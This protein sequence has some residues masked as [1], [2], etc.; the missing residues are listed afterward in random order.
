MSTT[1]TRPQIE[2][3]A[4][5][6]Q[7]RPAVVGTNVERR[8]A[9]AKVRGEAKYAADIERPDLIHGKAVRSPHPRARI[10]AIDAAAA[11]ALPGV[12]AVL[13]AADIPGHKLVGA[14]AVKDQAVLAESMT[15]FVGE[16]VALV[17]AGSAETAAQGARLVKVDYEVLDPVTD[18]EEALAPRAP[19]LRPGGNLCHQLR[20][21]RG[22]FDVVAAAAD[23]VVTNTYTTQA[24]DHGY[25]EPDAVVAEP[26]GDGVTLYVSSK[27]PHNDQGEIAGVLAMPKDKVHI[28]VVAVGGSF[29]GKPDIPMLCMAGLM[30]ARYNRPAK[31]VL[32]REECLA[33]KTKRHAYKMVYS[34]AVRANG[35]ILGLRVR[36]VADA[37]AYAG[38]TPTV[39]S[40]GLIH[41]AGP[42]RAPVVDMEIKAAYTNNPSGGAMRGYGVPQT[43]FAAERQMDVIARRLGISPFE[44]RMRNIL[45]AG[46]VTATGQDVADGSMRALMELTAQRAAAL[47]GSGGRGPHIRRAWG[48]GTFFYGAGRTGVA[49]SARVSIGLQPDGLVHV[50]VGT[51]DTGQ[52]SDTAL[53]QIAAEELG[54]PFEMVQLT[55]ADTDL[56]YDCG[57]STA[58]RVTYVVG[59]A[60]RR[61]ATELKA[62]LLS[63]LARMAG[64][65]AAG[66]I[67]DRD[68]LARLSAY[69]LA[70]GLAGEAD[71]YFETTTTKMD[72]NGQGSPYGAYTYGVQMSRVAVNTLTGKVDV[73]RTVCAYDA[74][75]VVNP[76]LLEGQIEG[77]SATAQGY[78]LTEDLGLKEG[79]LSNRNLDTYLM[80]TAADIPSMDVSYLSGYEKSGPFGAKG[81]GEPTT[82]PGAAAIVNAIC[83]A[84]GCELFDLPVTPERLVK[85]MGEQIGTAQK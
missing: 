59:S 78:A 11:L 9:V 77:G 84:T 47:N 14:R 38:Y 33:A 16:A 1:V 51:P 6:P 72:A 4:E 22:D 13:T 76:R 26:D 54:L 17:V 43:V 82:L 36:I 56:T 8:D 21:A 65:P 5:L 30:A 23:L 63:S 3:V 68:Q 52:G 24:V 50:Y 55:S 42:Y 48:I 83:Q 46:D 10:L 69:A 35:E 19:L 34:H 45:L 80:P 81:V 20:I 44:M 79:F 73:E 40:K 61:A 2:W 62:L 28:V 37:G 32:E 58:S 70:N 31:M 49:D 25:I 39:V 18:P 7:G 29:G 71:G 15:S 64:A 60:V 67:A 27:S 75:T 12:L 85:A 57:T 66:L 74:G 41:A 53:A